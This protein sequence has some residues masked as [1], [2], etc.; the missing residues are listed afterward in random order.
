MTIGKKQLRAYLLATF[1]IFVCWD[2][3]ASLKTGATHT[4]I[5]DGR[6][7]SKALPSSAK[8]Q[9][10]S[11]KE[12]RDP[13]PA[14]LTVIRDHTIVRL[15]PTS[16]VRR[17]GIVMKGARLPT[18][19]S[20][21]GPGCK[22]LWYKV[23]IDGWICGDLVKASLL[24][25]LGSRYPIVSD[26]ALT[27][28]PYGF[29]REPTIEY[30]I[31][32]GMLEEVREVLTG[33]GFG[34][35]GRVLVSGKK[36]FRTAEKTLIPKEAAGIAGR[37][38]DFSG[39]ALKAG[40][41]WPVG[42]VNSR[43]ADAS[44][45][46][47][48]AKKFRIG[49]VERYTMFQVLE[50]S[51]IGRNRFFRFDENAWLASKDVRISTKASLPEGLVNGERWIDVD[52]KQQIVTAYEGETP[53]YVTLVSTGRFGASRTVKGEYRIWAKVAA[54][55]MDNTDEELE[56]PQ[57]GEPDAGIALERKLYSLHDVPWAQFF[58]ESYGLHGVY[59]HN[60]FGN[61]R[62]HGCINLAPKDARWFFN[63]TEPHL[64]DGWWAMH[65]SSND[66]G[67]LIRIR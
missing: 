38:S 20:S 6:D 11:P 50:E 18:L 55:P 54:I 25:P 7:K 63:W 13:L 64:P 62:S 37:I 1:A 40:S 65:N 42:F 61:R 58:F 14:S 66:N 2:L 45:K 16:R 33:F 28:W 47:T 60:R 43:K 4:N 53:V 49:K 57:E 67:T 3:G 56:E 44:S 32:K 52:T 34:V 23:H 10:A 22:K 17:R 8:T 12:D 29:V 5:E 48:R 39:I 36:F 21:K 59:W 41:P 9:D 24:P 31:R 27:P 26:G 46:P 15:A 19:D 35:E 51:G 30:R